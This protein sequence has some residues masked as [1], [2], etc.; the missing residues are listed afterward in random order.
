M[1]IKALLTALVGAA[2]I[3][4]A[5]D[6]RRSPVHAAM[7]RR[8]NRQG[9][10]GGNRG[11]NQNNNQNNNQGGNNQGGNN[12]GGNNQGGNNQNNGGGGGLQLAQNV[13]QRGSANDGNNPG[14]DQQAASATYVTALVSISGTTNGMAVPTTT[15]STFARARR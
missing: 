7:L 4:D 15:S 13:L 11:G 14:S 8:Q 12:R 3:V 2:M 6:I 10:N 5:A 1:Q 9:N